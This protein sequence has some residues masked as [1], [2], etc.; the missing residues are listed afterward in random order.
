MPCAQRSALTDWPDAPT[1]DA[2][3]AAAL[4]VRAHEIDAVG[5]SEAFIDLAFDIA[6]P[7]TSDR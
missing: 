3:L 7:A 6:E 5:I 4:E 2:R 1:I